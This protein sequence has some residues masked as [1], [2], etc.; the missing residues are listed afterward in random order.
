MRVLAKPYEEQPLMAAYA[1]PARDDER[2]LVTF[3]G[4]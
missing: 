2:V 1:E 4:T 3:C